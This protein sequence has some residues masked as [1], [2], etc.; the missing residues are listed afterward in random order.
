VPKTPVIESPLNASGEP[1][2]FHSSPVLNV[3]QLFASSGTCRC[4][5]LSLS[6]ICV[7]SSRPAVVLRGMRLT[8]AQVGGPRSGRT[9]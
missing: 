6:V 3:D 4:S 5:A 9:R 8:V 1:S 2:V 7:H